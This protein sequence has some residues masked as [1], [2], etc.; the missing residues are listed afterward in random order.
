M[1][2]RLLATVALAATAA[3]GLSA[4][5]SGGSGGGSG[6]GDKKDITIAV[7]NGWAEGEATSYLWQAI[8]EDK[9]YNVKL[10]GADAGPVFTGLAQGDYDVTF[11][12][13]L[14]ST[15]ADYWKTYGDKLEDLGSWYQNAPLTIA[16]NEDAPID[17][18]A[19]LAANADKFGNK[20][21]GIEPGAGLTKATAEKIIPQYGLD[22]ME[23]ETSSTA[24]MLAALKKATSQGQNIVVTL[25][26]PH[27]AYDAFPIKD[28]KD[29]KDAFG[30]PDHIDTVGRAGFT[31]DFPEVAK[32]FGNWE[33]PDEKLAELEKLMF[34]PDE[35]GN[36]PDAGEYPKIVKDWIAK[37]KDWVDSLTS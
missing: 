24:A 10:E 9:G 22:K 32:W 23:F 1:K 15:H 26:K 2:K 8:L 19:D 17:S 27:W 14:P 31:E 30:E 4:C 25:W 6:D 28:L 3:L 34:Q 36:T 33:F 5:S 20:I 12:V 29:P 11:D 18:L 13:W 7:F 37:N 16:V 21:I 35:S